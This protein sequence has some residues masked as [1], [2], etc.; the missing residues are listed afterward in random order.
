LNWF[1]VMTAFVPSAVHETSVTSHSLSETTAPGGSGRVRVPVSDEASVVVV[2]TS[3]VVGASVLAASFVVSA[4]GGS[5]LLGAC[6]PA[7]GVFSSP[8]SLPAAP[9]PI[10]SNN[11]TPLA[12]ASCQV[13]HDRAGFAGVKVPAAGGGGVGGGA[14]P[15][16]FPHHANVWVILACDTAPGQPSQL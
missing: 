9:M 4:A 16:C 5:V 7:D 11:D 15:I 1:S 3:G 8:D 10:P 13:F 6:V 2:A 12:A 14:S